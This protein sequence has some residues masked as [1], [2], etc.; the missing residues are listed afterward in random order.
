MREEIELGGGDGLNKD[1]LLIH[2][3]NTYLEN[4]IRYILLNEIDTDFPSWDLQ[5]DGVIHAVQEIKGMQ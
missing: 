4:T 3:F 1:A 2:L 5:F